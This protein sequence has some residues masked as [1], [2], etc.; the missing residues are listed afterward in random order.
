MELVH[1]DFLKLEDSGDSY[2]DI[3]VITDHFTGYAQAHLCSNQKAPLVAKVLVENF[4]QH[5]GLPDKIISDQGTNFESGLIQELCK[6]LG[7]KK[8]RTTPYH[9][10]TNG[11]CERFNRTLIGMLGTLPQEEKNKW[12][13]SLKRLVHAYNSSICRMTGFSPFFLMF[14]RSPRLPLDIELGLKMPSRSV[15]RPTSSYVKNLKKRLNWAHKIA[16]KHREE[17]AG[18]NKKQYDRKTRCSK[19]VEGD[20]C[21]VRTVAWSG[22]H[23]LQDRW[24]PGV[25]VVKSQ[26]IPS[27]PVFVVKCEETGKEK[28]LH[29]NLL[30]PLRQGGQLVLEQ[31]AVPS[32]A[33]DVSAEPDQQ[34][35]VATG[36][37][38]D[39]PVNG[40]PGGDDSKPG[41]G[42]AGQMDQEKGPVEEMP[43]VDL[44]S[45]DEPV[46]DPARRYPRRERRKPHWLTEVWS[47]M[48][49][50]TFDPP[51]STEEDEPG[52]SWSG[53]ALGDLL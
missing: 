15:S 5:Y 41:E 3:L 47:S 30:L 38:I 48:T 19:L 36:P 12:P 50:G 18:G 52:L 21:L 27:L 51:S 31:E 35:E 33:S 7:V 10:Q 53:G 46:R 8:I 26:P 28:T 24:D 23:K 39:G 44:D 4:F 2:R 29:R 16:I 20:T 45:D 42:E 1:I 14:G 25:Y 17:N 49:R 9:P 22:K 43:V 13:S 11:S 34:E 32:P 37:V 6:L 40:S